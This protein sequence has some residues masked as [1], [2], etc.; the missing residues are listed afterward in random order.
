MNITYFIKRLLHQL[1]A[2]NRHG[3]HSPD[4]YTLLDEKVYCKSYP[5]EVVDLGSGIDLSQKERRLV[6]CVLNHHRFEELRRCQDDFPVFE[7]NKRRALF[8]SS[9]KE[10]ISGMETFIY[11]GG[12]I[13]WH[14]PYQNKGFQKKFES[15]KQRGTDMVVLDFFHLAFSYFRP[16]QRGEVFILKY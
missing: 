12:L 3:T 6:S 15:F 9:E 2:N 14:R 16:E 4:V 11:Q 5:W 10:C 7:E 13:V 8:I 1:K